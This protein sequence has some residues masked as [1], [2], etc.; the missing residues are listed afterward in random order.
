VLNTF[1]AGT[2]RI[3]GYEDASWAGERL[4]AK[5][6]PFWPDTAR[7]SECFESENVAF[8]YGWKG[9]LQVFRQVTVEPL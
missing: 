5:D 7:L 6:Y 1:P 2:P 9:L 3:K 4:A 8:S